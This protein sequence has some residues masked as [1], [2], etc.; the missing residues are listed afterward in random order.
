MRMFLDKKIKVPGNKIKIPAPLQV[1]IAPIRPES[2]SQCGFAALSNAQQ[3]HNRK[4]TQQFFDFL[5]N[6]SAF[7][8]HIRMIYTNFTYVKA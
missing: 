2:F 8:S 5:L 6:I 3:D 7:F 4:K 1:K